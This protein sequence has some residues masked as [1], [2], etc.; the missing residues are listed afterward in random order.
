MAIDNY[1]IDYN[2]IPEKESITVDTEHCTG[3]RSCE[4]A[5]SY[6]HIKKYAPSKS[7]IKIFRDNSN[8][9][10]KFFFTMSCDLCKDEMIPSCAEVCH[11]RAIVLKRLKYH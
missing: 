4:I 5:C 8:G 11:K 3:C 7:S 2:E 1:E 9:Q 6:H 10:I